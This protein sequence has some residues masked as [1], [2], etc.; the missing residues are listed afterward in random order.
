VVL[1]EELSVSMAEMFRALA[2]PSRAKIVHA[3]TSRTH[4]HHAV[5]PAARSAS[6][7]VSPSASNTCQAAESASMEAPTVTSSVEPAEDANARMMNRG[8]VR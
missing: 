1:S 2:D 8:T 3:L 7:I 5:S 6:P 4:M